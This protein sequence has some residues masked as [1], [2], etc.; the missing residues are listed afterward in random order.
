MKLKNNFSQDTREMF[1][2]CWECWTCGENGQQSGG[3]EIHHIT[4]RN[5]KATINASVL[6]KKCHIQIN[7]NRFEEQDL[8]LKT[9]KYLKQRCYNIKQEDLDHLE[10]NPHLISSKLKEWLKQK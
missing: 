1:R 2:D 8:T 7:H 10:K 5:S 6:C 4:G 9:L 3:L